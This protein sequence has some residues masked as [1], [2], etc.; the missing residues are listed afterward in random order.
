MTEPPRLVF[1]AGASRSGST[2][3]GRV[4]GSAPGCV[5][6]G[7]LTFMWDRGL[8][9]NQLCGCGTR[10]ADCPF[11]TP[12]L[13]ETFGR[14]Q[15]T[16]NQISELIRVRDAVDYLPTLVG[17][18]RGSAWQRDR[19][20]YADVLARLFESV[21]RTTGASVVI[22]SS[23]RPAHGVLLGS[24][25]GN[26]ELHTVHL[27]RDARGVCYSTLRRRARPEIPD[28]VEYMPTAQ[29]WRQAL[30][31][32]VQNGFA[33]LVKR[34]SQRSIF[35]RYEDF[36]ERPLSTAASVHRE[37]GLPT[38]SGEGLALQG[39]QHVTLAMEHTVSGNPMRFATGAIEVRPDSEWRTRL[40]ARDRRLVSAIASPLLWRYGYL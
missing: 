5:H 13:A 32:T 23:K 27:V 25:P 28:A 1:I 16:Q 22:D 30:R 12:V 26:P 37:I 15:L 9:Q 11:W 21:R 4:L 10:F 38:S 6:I 40:P 39:Q 24:L 8:R 20:W 18:S 33:T 17:A 7:E 29:P 2:L 3:L 31:W 36:V 19:D 35:I 14:S 34:R